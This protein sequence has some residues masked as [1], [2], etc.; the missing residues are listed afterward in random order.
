MIRRWLLYIVLGVA[1]FVAITYAIF[2]YWNIE[3]GN[4]WS[5][6]FSFTSTFGI[7]A[8]IGVYLVQDSKQTLSREK[9]IDAHKL[10]YSYEF[11]ENTKFISL[12]V[13]E[14]IDSFKLNYGI[15]FSET[16]IEL[17]KKIN[18]MNAME[19]TIELPLPELKG[20]SNN[21]KVSMI[22]ESNTELSKQISKEAT[23]INLIISDISELKHIMT[24]SKKY[25]LNKANIFFNLKINN[26]KLKELIKNN[27]FTTLH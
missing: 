16:V 7:L 6:F 14:L 21:F 18:N 9:E 19:V 27:N 17:T 15:D 10:I 2:S 20:Y 8:T 13:D 11:E 22:S 3:D 4:K 26:E 23:I 24:L 25:N 5:T 1:I 12:K